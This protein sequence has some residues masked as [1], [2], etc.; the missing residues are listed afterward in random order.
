MNK[1]FYGLGL[2]LVLDL[3]SAA[4]RHE[5]S[6]GAEGDL[7]GTRNAKREKPVATGVP[8]EP[9]AAEADLQA[10]WDRR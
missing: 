8:S 1:V 6:P 5:K 9:L 4:Q 2:T 7:I 10:E 3:D